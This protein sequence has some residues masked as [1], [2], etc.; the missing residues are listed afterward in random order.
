MTK[1]DLFITS[2]TTGQLKRGWQLLRAG[3]GDRTVVDLFRPQFCYWVHF[4]GS[5][6]IESWEGRQ[7]WSGHVLYKILP[8]GALGGFGGHLRI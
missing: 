1:A 3:T 2:F 4:E 6:V 5:V 7:D 8:R